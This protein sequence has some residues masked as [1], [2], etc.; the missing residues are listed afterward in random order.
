MKAKDALRLAAEMNRYFTSANDIDVP[1]RISIPRDE[2]RQLYAAMKDA[3]EQPSVS[4]TVKDESQDWTG[5]DGATAF[6]LIQRHAD[7]WG[8]AG[9][10][11]Q[12]W[13]NANRGSAVQTASDPVAVVVRN[14]SG[15]VA[16]KDNNGNPFDVS[17]YVGHCFYTGTPPAKQLDQAPIYFMRDNHT[18]K[19]LGESVSAALVEIEHEF[20]EGWTYGC[21][22]SKREGFKDVTACG[23]SKRL[24]FF[25]ECKSELEKWLP[26]SVSNP[27]A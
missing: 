3:L 6:W 16:L 26:T 23:S 14:K 20:N 24:E 25:A 27:L 11:M 8:D 18:F 10:M 12:E 1:A 22:C 21:L 17:K 7:G 13:L 19:K 9:K 4:I 5:M 2:W 15:Q